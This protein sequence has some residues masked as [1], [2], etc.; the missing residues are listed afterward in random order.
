MSGHQPN[1]MPY[2]GF[3]DKIRAVGE[4]GNK[5]SVFLIVGFTQ[6]SKTDF[7]HRNK[8]RINSGWKW[9]NVPVYH[10][11]EPIKNQLN[12]M[13][14]VL[15]KRENMDKT[16]RLY[17]KSIMS[18]PRTRG[19]IKAIMNDRLQCDGFPLARE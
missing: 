1:F 9:I 17:I 12:I 8:I 16:Q 4:K 5:K 19:S 14:K 11:K 7:H 2:P 10:K 13:T 18:S 3:F 6:Y 15:S